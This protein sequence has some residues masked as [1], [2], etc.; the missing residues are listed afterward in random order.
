L[1]E[2]WRVA[3]FTRHG[4]VERFRKDCKECDSEALKLPLEASFYKDLAAARRAAWEECTILEERY[5]DICAAFKEILVEAAALEL[6]SRPTQS[7][8]G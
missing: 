6:R 3:A 5:A 1:K 8:G 7:K 4:S 2:A